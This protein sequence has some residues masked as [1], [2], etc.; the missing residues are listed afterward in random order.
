LPGVTLEG[1]VE[2]VSSVVDPERHSVP[3]RVLLENSERKL[4]PNTYG[5]MQFLNPPAP[6]SVQVAATA[7]V[8]DGARQHVYI[9]TPDGSFTRRDVVT[10]PTQGE[11]TLVLSGLTPGQIIVQRGAILLDNQIALSQ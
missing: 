3:V 9:R 2:M 11:K 6:G 10:G 8:S 1:T 4:K 7:V 5:R